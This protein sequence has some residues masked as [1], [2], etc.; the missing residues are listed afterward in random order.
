M[1]L[2]TKMLD[3]LYKA[4]ACVFKPL[5][6]KDLIDLRMTMAKKG[7]PPIPADYLQFLNLTDGLIY[8]GLLFFGIKEHD[9]EASVYTYPSILSINE[10][11]QKRNRR[12][13]VLIVGE[14]DEDFIIYRPKEKMYQL[15]DRFDMIG[16]LNLPRFLDVVYFFNQELIEGQET[17]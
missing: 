10:D 13:D 9:R 2:L 1:M 4:N 12:K 8:N 15:M 6:E 14:K 11:F 7:L 5:P 17:L 16:D 3:R